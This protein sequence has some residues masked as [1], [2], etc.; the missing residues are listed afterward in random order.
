MVGGGTD[1]EVSYILN[2]EIRM[3]EGC[4]NLRRKRGVPVVGR[5]ESLKSK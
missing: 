2:E 1:V 5:E 4:G 3:L